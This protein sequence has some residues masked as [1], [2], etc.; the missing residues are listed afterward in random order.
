MCVQLIHSLQ[1]FHNGTADID[2][3]DEPNVLQM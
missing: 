2:Q 3:Q 1:M